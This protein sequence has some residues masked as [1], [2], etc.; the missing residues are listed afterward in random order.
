LDDEL[1]PQPAAT[2]LATAMTPM[3][4][5]VFMRCNVGVLH[6]RPVSPR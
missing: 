2:R 5:R 6:Q 3:A 1:E 4:I